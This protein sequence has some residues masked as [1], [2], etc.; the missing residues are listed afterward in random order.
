MNQINFKRS[1]KWIQVKIS[2]SQNKCQRR[3]TSCLTSQISVQDSN[4][5]FEQLRKNFS[6]EARKNLFDF[7]EANLR[8]SYKECEVDFNLI[9]TKNVQNGSRLFRLFCFA[10]LA[11]QNTFPLPESEIISHF[12]K[13]E[14][15]IRTLLLRVDGNVC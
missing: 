3:T 7:Y 14:A 9:A 12:A 4:C 13:C 1:S 11:L 8:I 6:S 5:R 10:I 2:G 15:L